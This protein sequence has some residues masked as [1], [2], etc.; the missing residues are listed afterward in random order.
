M[1]QYLKHSEIDFALWDH[2]VQ[3]SAQQMLY[4]C[5]GYLEVSTNEN[6][7]AIV[8][9]QNGK[10]VSVFPLPFKKRLGEK[11]IYQPFHSQQLGLFTTSESKITSV[12]AYLSVIPQPFR[13]I[14]LQLNT[15]NTHA[16][17]ALPEGFSSEPR[18][19]YHLDLA[20]RYENLRE[21]YATNL[22]RNLKKAQQENF[23]VTTSENL[24]ELIKLYRQTRGKD[25]KDV[26]DRHYHLFQ[27]QYA[28]LLKNASV[29]ISE[30]RKNGVLIAG[31]LFLKQP[32]KLIFLFSATSETGKKHG[33]MAF[34]LDQLVQQHAG[35]RTI[36]DFE[37]SSIPNLARF[38]SSFGAKPVSYLSVSRNN[39]PAYLKLLIK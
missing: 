5:A 27:N 11:F 38:Y 26:K 3:H 33:A 2:C 35:S 22:K 36:L 6:W 16:I 12:S 23:Q 19:T 18:V 1:L 10:Y 31:A 13:K 39:L 14:Y 25:L 15:S 4:A 17:G 20:K 37:G 28:F 7:D 21:N 8:E 9:I 30:I 24:S 29:Q 34:I 32:G